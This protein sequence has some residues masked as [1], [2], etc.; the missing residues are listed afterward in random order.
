MSQL[1][2]L[3]IDNQKLT[4]DNI[5]NQYHASALESLKLQ[6]AQVEQEIEKQR[7]AFMDLDKLREAKIKAYEDKITN[8]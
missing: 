8:Y 1:S 4:Q 3:K 5:N 2:N 6:K 7:N